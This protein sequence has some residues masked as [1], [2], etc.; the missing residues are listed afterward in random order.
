MIVIDFDAPS[1][2]DLP[3]RPQ[4]LVCTAV[5]ASRHTLAD[6]VTGDAKMQE[7]VEA[8]LAHKDE[9]D[10]SG[11]RVLTYDRLKTLMILLQA[12]TFYEAIITRERRVE[13]ELATLKPHPGDHPRNFLVP[14][15]A[16]G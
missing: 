5:K 11:F 14:R 7:L 8:N 4:L 15:S 1:I 9:Y 12:S 6:I 16:A 2:R 13:H 3:K 10:L